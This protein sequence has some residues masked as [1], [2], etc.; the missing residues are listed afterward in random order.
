MKF[1]PLSPTDRKFNLAT[2]KVILDYTDLVGFGAGT[3][4]TVQIF[5]RTG[6]FPAGVIMRFAGMRLSTSFGFSDVSINSLLVE[7]GDTGSTARLLSQTQ[8][9]TAGTP[10]INK[11]EPGNTQPY[12]YPTANT[13]GAKFT[14]AGGA[15]PTLGEATSGVVEIYLHVTDF[16]N[17]GVA[18]S[19]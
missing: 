3:T 9:A 11:V 5:P 4:G 14:V 17:L 16:A 10:V 15:S 13:V 8:I 18:Q 6:T 7:V 1:I 19:P 12:S 2:H